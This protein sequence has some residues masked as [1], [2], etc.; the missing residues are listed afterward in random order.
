MILCCR[1]LVEKWAKFGELLSY[2]TLCKS[3]RRCWYDGKMNRCGHFNLRNAY[4]KIYYWTDSMWSPRFWNCDDQICDAYY[5]IGNTC[6][7]YNFSMT[8]ELS[9]WYAKRFIQ[10]K[11]DLALEITWSIWFL[12]VNFSSRVTPKSVNSITCCIGLLNN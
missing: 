10:A 1:K 6:V 5:K 7:I 2:H 12:K 9:K 3:K 4:N 8:Q 11:N